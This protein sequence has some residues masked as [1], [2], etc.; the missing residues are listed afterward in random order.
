MSTWRAEAARITWPLPEDVDEETLEQKLFPPPGTN[1]ERPVPDWHE[2]HNELKSKKHVTLRLVWLEWRER[3]PD[4]WGY[5]QFCWHYRRWLATQDVVM[6]LAYA[7]GERM[8]VDFS[9][10]KAQWSDPETGEVHDADVFVA[11]LGCSGMLYAEATRGQDLF[12]W[13]GAHIHAWEAY[14]GVTEITVPDNLRAGVT[15]ACFY[16]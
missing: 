2:I 12:S 15:K 10:D 14:G 6:R 7:A 5:S 9:G 16:D 13:T 1:P 11:V 8:F 4:G 3:E